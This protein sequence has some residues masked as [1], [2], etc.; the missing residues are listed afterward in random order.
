MNSTGQPGS[1]LHYR[2]TPLSTCPTC[3]LSRVHWALSRSTA[4]M[5]LGQPVPQR[6]GLGWCSGLVPPD[7]HH[8]TALEIEKTNRH[9][10]SGIQASECDAAWGHNPVLMQDW[11][12]H[13]SC[14]FALF[15]SDSKSKAA[16]QVSMTTRRVA[17]MAPQYSTSSIS[18]CMGQAESGPLYNGSA[19]RGKHKQAPSKVNLVL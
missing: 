4:L 3:L 10:Y 17:I 9:T 18:H 16:W 8:L 12:V 14:L 15:S 1:C 6:W 5:V 2:S 13:A 7:T 11:T 19:S